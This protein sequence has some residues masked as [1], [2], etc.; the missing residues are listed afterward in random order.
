LKA[1]KSSSSLEAGVN[2]RHLCQ[3]KE[4]G[5]SDN[6]FRRQDEGIAT[7]DNSDAEVGNT[8]QQTK[9]GQNVLDGLLPHKRKNFEKG[10]HRYRASPQCEQ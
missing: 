7:T 10:P 1:L 9:P 2:D 5:G 3:V 4:T 6:L 8:G